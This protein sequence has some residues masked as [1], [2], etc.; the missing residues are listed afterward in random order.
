MIAIDAIGVIVVEGGGNAWEPDR[1]AHR[2]QVRKKC[3]GATTA[4]GQGTIRAHG[5]SSGEPRYTPQEM[6]SSLIH[7]PIDHFGGTEPDT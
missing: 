6:Q 7:I 5:R 2:A 3:P 4:P 1:V